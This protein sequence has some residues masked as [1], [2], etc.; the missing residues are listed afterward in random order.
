MLNKPE[1]PDDPVVIRGIPPIYKCYR[2]TPIGEALIDTLEKYKNA[3][4]LSENQMLLV[5]DEFDRSMTE[6]LA[7]IEDSSCSIAG[8]TSSFSFVYN[9]YRIFMQP[10]IIQFKD[11]SY[12]S[13]CLQIFAVRDDEKDKKN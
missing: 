11:R 12:T 13:K 8:T 4:M 7:N 10:A 3:N 2:S 5:L 9:Y 6:N 1:H